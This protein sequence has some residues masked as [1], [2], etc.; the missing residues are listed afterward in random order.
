MFGFSFSSLFSWQLCGGALL[1]GIGGLML[2]VFVSALGRGYITR[3]EDGVHPPH[4]F[5]EWE[6]MS[7]KQRIGKRAIFMIMV[8]VWI[9]ISG[10]IVLGV[11]ILYK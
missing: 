7:L 11:G 3:V 4:A 5:A 6:Q 2:F 9:L 8:A 1:A 10:I